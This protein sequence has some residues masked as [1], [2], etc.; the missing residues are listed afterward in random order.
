[1][2]VAECS[3]TPTLQERG[4]QPIRLP[5]GLLGFEDIKDYV[6]LANPGEEPF[7]WLQVVNNPSL[8]FL[9]LSPFSV[10]PNYRPDIAAEDAEFLKLREAGD[11]LIFNIVTM[12]GAQNAT[13]NLKGPIVL[14]RHTLIG[15]QV[16]PVNATEYSV[17]YPLS[18]AA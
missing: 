15:K 16:I 10:L 18:P 14:N 4:Q 13:L 7:L 11:A 12:R 6:L 9:V 2:K 5:L 17:Q 3:E 1:M 8:A